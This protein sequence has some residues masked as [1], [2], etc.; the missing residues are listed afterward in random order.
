[1]TRATSDQARGTAGSFD[2]GRVARPSGSWRRIVEVDVDCIIPI[3]LYHSV[4]DGLSDD[5]FATS[6]AM[7]EAH[8]DAMKACGRTTLCITELADALR[9][10]RPLPPWTVAVTF[11]DGFAN[12]YDAVHALLDRGISSTVYVT[13]GDVGTAD[14]LNRSQV[15]ELAHTPNVEIGAH[16]VHHCHLDELDGHEVTQ[17]VEGSKLELEAMTGVEITSFAYP[18]GSHDRRVRRAV[19]DAGYTSAAG[20]KNAVSHRRDD[21]FGIARWTVTATTS[22]SRIM[23]VLEGQRVPVAWAGERVRTRAYRMV[24]RSRRRLAHGPT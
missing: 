1:V 11:D 22:P 19:I 9:E 21:P 2:D 17:E 12:T 3:L 13:S 8:A 18:H 16:A 4:S 24:R 10:G 14:R 20:V 7:F 6:R 15:A 5:R 23:Q